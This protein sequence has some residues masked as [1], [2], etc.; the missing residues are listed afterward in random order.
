MEGRRNRARQHC[1]CKSLPYNSLALNIYNAE[2]D[3][4]IKLRRYKVFFFYLNYPADFG[5][6]E[7]CVNRKSTHVH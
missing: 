6:K 4:H 1:A 5:F 3:A 7:K 2:N